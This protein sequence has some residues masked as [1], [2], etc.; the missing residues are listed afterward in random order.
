MQLTSVQV[1]QPK[2][3]ELQFSSGHSGPGYSHPDTAEQLLSK[4]DEPEER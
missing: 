3:T 2:S 1:T 4:G